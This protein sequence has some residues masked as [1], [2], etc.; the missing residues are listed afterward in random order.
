MS[1]GQFDIERFMA[2]SGKVCLDDIRWD[3]VKKYPLTPETIRVLRVFMSVESSTLLYAK[4]LL[5]ARTALDEPFGPF[6]AAWVYEEEFHGRAFRAFLQAY[7]DTVPVELERSELFKNRKLGEWFD[8]FMQRALP[9]VFPEDFPAVHMTWGAIQELTTYHCY[10]SLVRRVKHPILVQ[11]CERIMKQELK[12]FSFYYQQAQQRLSQRKAAQLLTKAVLQASWTPVGAGI[13]ANSEIQHTIRFL[14]DGMHGPIIPKIEAKIRELPGQFHF[15]L[16]TKY[17]RKHQLAAAP[18]QWFV[19][20]N[21]FQKVQQ[22]NHELRQQ[23]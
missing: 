19:D 5:G 15:N 16:F 13:V 1:V 2:S 18:V 20:T 6:L 22:E 8:E 9:M 10:Q 3:D 12:H 11:I 7:G 17:A 14:F 23:V 21:W 4:A